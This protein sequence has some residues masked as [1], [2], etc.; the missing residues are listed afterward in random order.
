LRNGFAM[1]LPPLNYLRP[2]EATARLGST[3]RAGDELGRTHSAISR[4]ITCFEQWLGIKLFSRDGG[5]LTLTDEGQRYHEAISHVLSLLDHATRSL[6]H[7]DMNDVIRVHAATVFTSRW[8]IPRIGRFYARHPKLEVRIL[9]F[10]RKAE[11]TRGPCDVVVPLEPGNWPDVDVVPLMPDVIFPVCSPSL[12][13]EIENDR[14]LPDHRLLHAEDSLADWSRWLEKVGIAD[15]DAERGLQMAD[16]E[17]VLKAAANGH[18]IALARGQ[19]VMDDLSSGKLVRP[20][21]LATEVAEAYWIVRSKYGSI[22]PA[23]RAFTTWMRDE[24]KLSSRRFAESLALGPKASELRSGHE[25]HDGPD[26]QIRHRAPL[27]AW[28][29]AGRGAEASLS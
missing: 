16:P 23:I 29:V 10:S 28:R 8:L 21:P 5:R 6:V 19:L 14:R 26:S 7:H 4:Q 27:P 17:N 20:I 13:S 25:G 24:A 11:L 22:N 1:H 12:A 9:D 3:V 2:F 18:G 15:L